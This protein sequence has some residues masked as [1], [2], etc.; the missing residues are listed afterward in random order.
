ME[1]QF[2][3][4]DV[5]NFC[6]MLKSSPSIKLNSFFTD[7]L[8]PENP[9]HDTSVD[10][11]AKGTIDSILEQYPRYDNILALNMANA[12]RVG[13]GWLTGAEAQEEYLFRRTDL[14]KTLRDKLYPM[15]EDEVIYSPSV[16]VLFD[17]EYS[18]IDPEHTV[19]FVS[20]AAVRD[21][22]I[23][24]DG[25]LTEYDW[26]EMYYK[27]RLIFHIA[28]MNK[29]DCLILGAL[30]CGAF[31]N[32]P[33]VIATIFAEMCSEY[34]G[35][36]KKVVFAIKSVRGDVNCQIFQQVF[37]ETFRSDDEEKT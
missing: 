7:R 2:R 22:R 21:P 24:R 17:D 10:L 20:V 31:H 27:V 12:T 6:R 33:N 32:P 5:I 35:H 28:A 4:Q 16:R 8:L 36:F 25:E 1:N 18:V 30:G 14:H 34:A 11:E 29:H 15:M 19:A 37:L 26:T 3:S 9:N 13:G 23:T